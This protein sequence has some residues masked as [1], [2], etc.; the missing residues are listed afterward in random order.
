SE[1]AAGERRRDSAGRVARWRNRSTL[2]QRNV[3]RRLPPQPERAA[4]QQRY[5]AGADPYLEPGPAREKIS[6]SALG[7]LL[8]ALANPGES[9]AVHAAWSEARSEDSLLRRQLRQTRVSAPYARCPP[10]G[11]RLAIL[12]K[13]RH[14][15][16][17]DVF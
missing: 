1:L 17:L 5:A 4:P 8:D 7:H 14:R 2:P 10:E 6:G 12:G 13:L 15:R 11:D 3:H 16:D 9:G